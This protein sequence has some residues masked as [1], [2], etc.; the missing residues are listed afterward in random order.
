MSDEF[1]MD[2]RNFSAGNDHL[3]TALDIPDGV[4][5]AMGYY[6]PDNTYTEDGTFVIRVDEGPVNGIVL[7]AHI[8][9][10]IRDIAQK[11]SLYE[12]PIYVTSSS[13]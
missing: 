6:S 13:S 2:G 1:E 10:Y 11:L 9:I 12:S 3:W 7:S 8:Y 5:K 4:N